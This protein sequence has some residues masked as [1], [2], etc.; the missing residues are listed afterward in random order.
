MKV[1][2]VVGTRPE[3]IRLSR[4]MSLLDKHTDH[5][6][7]H[8]GQN[9]DY[10]LNE[11][12]FKDL[13]LRKPDYFLN[14]DVSSLEA[15][16]GDIIRKSGELLR[17]EKPDALLVLG[18]TNSCLSAYMAKRLHIPIFHM[19]AGNRCFDF[20]V[21]E[22]INRRVI[23]HISDFN[24]VYTEHARRHLISEGL[25]HRRIYLT[26]SP[27]FEV[28]NYYKPKIEDSKI[29]ENLSLQEPAIGN[30]FLVSTHREENV[31]NQKNLHKILSVLNR[32]CEIYN[33]PVVV[34]THPRTRKRLEDV[35]D[36][37][38][39]PLIQFLKP[40]GFLDYNKLQ[41][42][43]KCTLS[44]SGTI[45]EESSI[46]NFPAISL[47]QSMERPEAQD[48]GTIILTGFEPEV[49]LASI[50]TAIKEHD[51][52]IPKLVSPDYLVPDTSWR[53]LKLILGLS[54]LSNKWHGINI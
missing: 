7:A 1:L 30:Y 47:R 19:E 16:V 4:V 25:P 22:E 40:F 34:S 41:M 49:V 42:C 24:L 18:D 29:L 9:Y 17:K 2:T 23:D 8:T 45:S 26:G 10:E 48:A 13:E 31:D 28:L 46:L 20:N 12:F 27:M 33:L 37:K 14:V 43:A 50:E 52:N 6:I 39:N 38:I 5:V 53:V 54:S 51:Q 36:I 44:D 32:L 3:I 35:T 21:P 11:I 15:S